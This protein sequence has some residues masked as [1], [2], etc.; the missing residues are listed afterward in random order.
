M[1]LVSVQGPLPY[2]LVI[3]GEHTGD[4][5]QFSYSDISW[6]STDANNGHSKAW[7]VTPT[8]GWDP[9]QGPT[10]YIDGGGPVP[11]IVPVDY[12]SVGLIQRLTDSEEADA[13]Q[14]RQMDCSFNC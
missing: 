7:C 2:S 13:S 12:H 8:G 6:K 9:R 4:Y 10:C 11:V 3:T 14:V 5:V 1:T